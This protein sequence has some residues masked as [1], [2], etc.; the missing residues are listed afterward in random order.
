MKATTLFLLITLLYSCGK[1]SNTPAPANQVNNTSNGHTNYVALV[2]GRSYVSPDSTTYTNAILGTSYWSRNGTVKL[3]PQMGV[4][5][6][7]GSA[8]QP[9]YEQYQDTLDVVAGDQ[10]ELRI[11]LQ[12]K[13]ILSTGPTGVWMTMWRNG[14]IANSQFL[15]V[16]TTSETVTYT[17]Q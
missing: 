10:I 1:D 11:N 4:I 17:V 7:A 9:G 15:S 12:H 13:W 14:S 5:C 16:D 3:I 6:K 2:L 8:V